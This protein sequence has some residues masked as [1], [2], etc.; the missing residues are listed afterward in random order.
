MFS[1]FAPF[2]I[3]AESR[4]I[5]ATYPPRHMPLRASRAQRTESPHIVLAHGS[6]SVGVDVEVIAVVAAAAV[7]ARKVRALGP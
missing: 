3:G 5:E 1:L 4:E 6:S 7:S 2:S